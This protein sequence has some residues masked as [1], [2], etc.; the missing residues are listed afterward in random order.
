MSSHFKKYYGLSSISNS[1]SHFLI[2]KGF[3][4]VTSVTVL[5]LLARYMEQSQYAVYIS[6]QAL[7]LLIGLISSAGFQAVLNRYVPELRATGNNLA[8][9]R[10]MLT[11]IVMRI[12]VLVL[13]MAIAMIFKD[14]I[15]GWLNFSEWVWI[16]PWYFFVGV[17]RLS[18]LSMSQS[19]ES[20][21]WQKDAQYSLAAGSLIRFFLVLLFIYFGEIDLVSVVII[22][23]IAESM[24]LLIISFRY[25]RKWKTDE[26]RSEGSHAWWGENKKRVIKFGFLNYLVGQSTL[27]YGSAPN[28]ILLASYMPSASLAQ[29]GFADGFANLS[30]RI[31]PTRLLIGFIRP[32]FM[33]RYSTNN[34]FE[35]LNGMSNFVFRINLMILL[36]PIA[37]LFVVGEPL[38]SW[39]TA[40]KYGEAAYLLAGFFILII[41]EGLYLL[42]E[43]LTQAI[44]KNQV[45]IV[46]NVIKSLSLFLAI[47][48]IEVLGVWSLIA[49]NIAGIIVA[50]LVVSIY[51]S[52]NNCHLRMDY[53]LIVLNVFYGVLSGGAGWLVLLEFESFFAALLTIF[54]IYTGLCIVKPPLYDEERK[55]SINIVLNS[56]R[57]K[58]NAAN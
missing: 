17:A 42:L 49:A 6:L 28:R 15:S 11:G 41:F 52:R 48:F 56:F 20:L 43:L 1:L 53:S 5:I 3:K 7:I 21:F 54:V 10:L 58:N 35:Q 24:A 12:L 32:I 36:L 22:E 14:A 13:V 27:L 23:A 38:F 51:L 19:M 33:A 40:G 2:G 8:M 9:Y 55:K 16:L 44:E 18:V 29:F 4:I 25:F 31:I 30:R 37:I 50:I 57:K 26:H 47:P 45:I 34:D 39:L 46:G